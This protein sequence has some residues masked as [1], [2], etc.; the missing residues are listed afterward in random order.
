MARRVDKRR[1]RRGRAQRGFVLVFALI[2]M[3]VLVALAAAGLQVGSIDAQATR[4]YRGAAQVH[5][6]AESAIAQAMQIVNGPGVVNFQNDVVGSWTTLFGT[7]P[8]NF[9]PLAGF[10]YTVSSFVNATNP[11][12]AGRFVAT[13]TGPEGV[14]KTI[15][16]SLIRSN[17]PATAPGAIYLSSD[18][19]TDADFNGNSFMVDGNDRNY[20]GGAG[21]GAPV[22]GIS[23]RH[24]ANTQEAIA[25]LSSRQLNNVVGLGFLVGPPTIPSIKTSPA[26]PSVAQINQIVA[27]LLALPGVVINNDNNVTGNAIFGTTLL[28]ALTYFPNS[29]EIKGNGNASGAGI[30]IVEG[31]L[32]IK[33]SLDFKGLILV[34]G[35]TQV[36]GDTEVTGNA[37]VYGS[38]WTNDINLIVGGSALVQYSSAALSLAN[39]IGGIAGALP[40]PVQLVSLADCSQLPAGAGGCP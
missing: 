14:R 10:T 6:V 3:T 22:P 4:N 18:T 28:P 34:R 11:A 12:S 21:P 9:V 39:T 27:D 30:M 13:A 25:S 16:A 17:I 8:R 38:I 36:V 37:T 33:G 15:V 20:L 19:P 23:T 26:A 1:L 7:A 5:Y 35:R 29:V 40:A 2:M 24:D 32:T 31:D